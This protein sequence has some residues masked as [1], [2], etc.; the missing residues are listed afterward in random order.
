M[1]TD[2]SAI[3][4][5]VFSRVRNANPQVADLY[6]L[7]ATLEGH[8]TVYSGRDAIREFYQGV[9]AT[10]GPH[11]VVRGLWRNGTRYAA[12]V[13]ATARAGTVAHAVDVFD[14]SG[15]VISSMRIFTGAL[16]DAWVPRPTG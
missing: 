7:D 11:P 3:V 4:L 1:A 5:E 6:A 10:T 15:G 9:F 14:V 8:G 13:E 2:D 16:S 12:L